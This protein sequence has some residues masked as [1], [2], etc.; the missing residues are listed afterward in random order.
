[1]VILIVLLLLAPSLAHLIISVTPSDQSVSALNQIT[2]RILTTAAI[3]SGGLVV[4][5]T[6]DFS[7]SP[8]CLVN[9]TATACLYATNTS[10][11]TVTFNYSFGS[12]LY[13]TLTINATNPIY[14]SNFPLTATASGTPFSNTAI[15]TILPNTIT[16][17][18]TTGSNYV[19]DSSRG[20][21]L[22]SNT[23]LPANSSITINSTQQSTFNNLFANNPTC[24]INTL[25]TPCLLSTS[26]G[27]QFL[28]FTTIPL[29]SNLT[30]TVENV[31]NAPYNAS[32]LNISL[33]VRHSS[34]NNMQTCTFTQPAPG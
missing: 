19:G 1:M 3:N 26:F 6:Q 21:F 27:S 23:P 5:L 11:S 29:A 7:P 14:A 20:T 9:G 17:S 4:A 10:S 12:G 16:C 32:L 8:P 18:L 22:L 25:S 31:N 34:G 15:I 33:Q 24:T 13:Y 28:T 2:L 30:L